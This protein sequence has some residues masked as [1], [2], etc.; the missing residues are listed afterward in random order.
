M[1]IPVLIEPVAGNGYRASGGS[2]FTFAAE[3]ATREEALRNLSELIKAKLGSGSRV[4]LLEVPV[5]ENPW[6]AMAGMWDKDDPLVQE[7]KQ[8][9]AENRQRKDADGDQP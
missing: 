7:W 4:A 1:E 9:M 3:G 6:V 5:E 8:I 2:P